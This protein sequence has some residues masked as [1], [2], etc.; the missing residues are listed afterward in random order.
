MDE[1]RYRAAEQRL[2]RSV[3]LDPTERYV[4]LDRLDTSIRVLEVGRGPVIVFVHGTTASAANWAPLVARLDGFR[5]VLLDRPGCGLSAPLA[6]DL[7]DLQCLAGIADNL[8]VDVLDALGVLSGYV[9]GTSLGGYYALRSA[10]AHPD[11]I[12]RMFEFGYVP[13]APLAHVPISMRAA[14]L[15]GASRLMTAIRPTRAAVRG[16]MRQLG[17][18]PAMKDGRVSTE[19]L[20]WYLS[21]LRDTPTLGNDATGPREILQKGDKGAVVLPPSLLARIQCPIGFVWGEDDPFGGADVALP[22]VNKMPAAEVELWAATGHAPWIEH[23]ER[24]AHRLTEFFG[25]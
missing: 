21:L 18:G 25:R 6:A 16:I 12:R 20:E 22:F 13:G 3:G 17:L 9:V 4:R 10:A 11:R 8:I 19:M 7:S 14:T 23:S 15:P 1:V 24:A 5:C 2:W